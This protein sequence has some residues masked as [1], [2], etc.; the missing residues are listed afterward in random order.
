MF[1]NYPASYELGYAYIIDIL[2][3]NNINYKDLSKAKEVRF[4]YP[5][6]R[7]KRLSNVL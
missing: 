7:S 4:S 6:I 3:L 5:I 2:G 1:P